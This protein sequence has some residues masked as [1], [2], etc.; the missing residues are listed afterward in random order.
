MLE[1]MNKY[2]ELK[3]GS[4]IR[5]EE[6]DFMPKKSTLNKKLQIFLDLYP[7]ILLKI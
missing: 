3:L 5:D 4:V 2:F 7:A 6:E 1:D